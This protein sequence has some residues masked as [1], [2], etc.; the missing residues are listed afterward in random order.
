MSHLLSTNTFIKHHQNELLGK[1]AIFKQACKIQASLF[2]YIQ[3]TQSYSD[4]WLHQCI[5]AYLQLLCLAHPG[6]VANS[7]QTGQKTSL[8]NTGLG[9]GSGTSQT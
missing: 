7:S 3:Q 5:D 9:D 4:R 8:G 6:L 1:K 2:Y